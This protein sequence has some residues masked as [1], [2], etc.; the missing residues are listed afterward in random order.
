MK[1]ILATDGSEHAKEAARL[2]ARLPHRDHLEIE[3]LFVGTADHLLGSNLPTD[4]LRLLRETDHV[5]A[6]SVFEEIKSLFDS[7][8][9]SLKLVFIEDRKSVV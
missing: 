6:Q 2:L 5:R 9:A 7:A 3:V 8:N 1:V 4:S